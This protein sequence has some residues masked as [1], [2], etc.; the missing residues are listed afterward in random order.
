MGNYL[1]IST[2]NLARLNN[3]EYL[4]YHSN[5]LHLI[6][7]D[8]DDDDNHRP[9]IESV[10]PKSITKGSS[11]LG[12]SAE[13]LNT[14]EEDLALMSDAVDESR[15]AQE[16]EEAILLKKDRSALASHITNRIARATSLPIAAEKEAGKF[17]YKIIKPYL[18]ITRLPSSQE[19]EKIRGLLIDL[20]KPENKSYTDALSLELYMNE[21]EKTNNAYIDTTRQRTESRAASKKDTG[22]IIRERMDEYYKE[23]ILVAQSY[24]IS[25][26]SETANTFIRNLNQLIFE[27]I[28]AYHQRGS[29][30]KPDNDKPNLN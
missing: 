1:L 24:S 5:F 22:A 23:A 20:R 18:N 25:H 10:E 11:A 12:L 28:T 3:A 8:E 9:E 21:L 17:L 7:L 4:A 16:T 26:P 14:Y 30:K 27:T 19:T 29:K 13:L 2:I 6:P 15:I